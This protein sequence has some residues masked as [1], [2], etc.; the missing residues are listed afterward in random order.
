MSI[1]KELTQ[2]RDRAWTT[3]GS[4]Y[5]ASR[6]LRTRS[7]LSLATISLIS[8]IGVAVPLL[9]A[10]DSVDFSKNALSLYSALLSLF[11]LVVAIIEGAA[12]FDAKADSLFRNAEQLNAFRLRVN[13]ALVDPNRH[14]NEELIKLTDEY[15]RLKSECPINHEV[16]DYQL[17]KASH[18]QDYGLKPSKLRVLFASA[19]F[20]T[21]STWWLSLILFAAVAGLCVVL[22]THSYPAQCKLGQKLKSDCTFTSLP[23]AEEP[24]QSSPKQ[25]PPSSSAPAR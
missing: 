20:I 15:D 10:T 9:L 25:I 21:Y 6:R 2:L 4:R 17:Q 19:R 3:S 23:Q 1:E 24:R 18:P 7:K 16:V 11:I 13:T 5:N 14:I 8:A 12:S 22:S